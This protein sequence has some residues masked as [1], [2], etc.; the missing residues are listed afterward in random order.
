MG[1]T[2]I[3]SRLEHPIHIP[4]PP[5]LR[6]VSLPGALR[7]RCPNDAQYGRSKSQNYMMM[8][9]ERQAPMGWFLS[10]WRSFR[11]GHIAIL[12]HGDVVVEMVIPLPNRRLR[13][14]AGKWKARR[15]GSSWHI[16]FPVAFSDSGM[17]RLD[18]PDAAESEEVPRL[19]RGISP[20]ASMASMAES[21]GSESYP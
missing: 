5:D 4:G 16:G 3:R 10:H 19:S 13:R 18:G 17:A 6:D 21:G 9:G 8:R 1:R 20:E 15:L 12:P 14:R 2:L 11:R 7:W